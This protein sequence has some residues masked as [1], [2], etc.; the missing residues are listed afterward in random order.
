M[1]ENE[2]IK[3]ECTNRNGCITENEC[4]EHMNENGYMIEMDAWTTST[5]TLE[6]I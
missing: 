5:L 4:N 2:S 3:N 6:E 1:T